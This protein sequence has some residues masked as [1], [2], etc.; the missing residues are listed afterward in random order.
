MYDVVPSPEALSE[1]GQLSDA[2]VVNMLGNLVLLES[3]INASLGNKAYSRKK[4]VYLASKLLL[5]QAISE[6]PQVGVNTKIDRAVRDLH[7]Y[8]SWNQQAIGSRQSQLLK[9][10]R[11]IWAVPAAA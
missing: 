11:E 1:F 8:P 6:R 2:S 7:A 9:L 5:V 4:E 3:P 10:A